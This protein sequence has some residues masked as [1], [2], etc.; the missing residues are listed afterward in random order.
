MELQYSNEKIVL[1]KTFFCFFIR[2]YNSYCCFF[3]NILKK[4]KKVYFSFFAFARHYLQNLF[5]FLFLVT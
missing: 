4:I 1:L 3:K 5:L 2:D